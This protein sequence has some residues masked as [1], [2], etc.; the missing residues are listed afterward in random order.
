MAN[1]RIARFFMEVAPPQ[2]VTVMRHRTSKMLDTITEDE[3]EI[4][5]N[6]S[7][8]LPPKTKSTVAVAASSASSAASVTNVKGRHFLKE[9]HRSLSILNQ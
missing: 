9:V 8:M 1:S 4:S 2:Y 7:V 6:D 5:T 3:R